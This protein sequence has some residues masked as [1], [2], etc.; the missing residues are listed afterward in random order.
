MAF[1]TYM[2]NKYKEAN[3]RFINEVMVGNHGR[4]QRHWRPKTGERL[5][6]ITKPTKQTM[7]DNEFDSKEAFIEQVREDGVEIDGRTYFAEGSGSSI[8]YKAE[9]DDGEVE[10]VTKSVVEDAFDEAFGEA[11]EGDE[12]E[13]EED[14]GPEEVH[15][16]TFYFSKANWQE[17][18]RERL[19]E[20]LESEGWRIDGEVDSGGYR[21]QTE[22]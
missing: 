12:G 20:M 10:T 9:D 19:E 5:T 22:R 18:D 14:E 17:E 16:G 8:R 13:P 21:I 1:S 15:L 4:K 7:S 3:R 2:K 11:D 6:N